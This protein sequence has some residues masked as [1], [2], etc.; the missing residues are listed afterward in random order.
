ML[1]A[2]AGF[3]VQHV[4]CWLL[5]DLLVGPGAR[6]SLPKG[7]EGSNTAKNEVLELTA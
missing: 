3:G 4:C 7:V 6:P 5:S 2:A 1:P